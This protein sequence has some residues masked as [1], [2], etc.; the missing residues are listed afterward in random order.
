MLTGD[1]AWELTPADEG[2]VHMRLG[3]LGVP[4]S[5]IAA[6]IRF[7]GSVGWDE[8]DS[9]AVA[10]SLDHLAK[11]LEL[12]LV[13][14]PCHTGLGPDDKYAA[15]RVREHL[16]VRSWTLDEEL[17]APT[18]K[19]ILG[20]AELAVGTANHFCVFA[21]SMG[22]PV[23]GLHSSPYMTQKIVGL[24]ELWP[25]RVRALSKA[26]GLEPTTMTTSAREM[27]DW[28]ASRGK[29]DEDLPST[30]VHRDAP[31]QYLARRLDEVKERRYSARFVDQSSVQ[32]YEHEF[33]TGRFMANISEL[34]SAAL[35]SVLQPYRQHGFQRHLDFACGTGRA[36]GFVREIAKTS[37]G[38]DV[39]SEML[40]RA[41]KR[42]PAA[43]FVCGHVVEVTRIC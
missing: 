13:F 40:A 30:E 32:T 23:I 17:D 29:A 41:K 5:F 6:Q 8:G 1:D 14:V 34:E 36:T 3:S 25:N 12:P 38:V 2:A 10:A 27:L 18:A 15:S 37:V 16:N 26:E 9:T 7:G 33:E 28:K 31:I 11:A 24:A 19:A 42:F 4:D 35:R 22:T 39:S 43:R 20:R 21:A